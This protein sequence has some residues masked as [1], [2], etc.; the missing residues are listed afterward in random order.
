MAVL[1]AL[2]W[3]WG[4]VAV[5]SGRPAGF[6]AQHLSGAG[7]TEFLGLYGLEKARAG[8]PEVTTHPDGERWRAA[9]ASAGDEAEKA[10]PAGTGVERKGL[11]VTLH[12]RAVPALGPEVD[13]LAA[14]VAGRHGLSP[15][16]GKMS[17]ELRP[18]VEV[19]KGTVIEELSSGLAAVAFAGD[20]IGDLPAFEALDA[21]R[22]AGV[23]TLSVASGG[24]ETPPEIVAAADLAVDG[25]EGI[26]AVL[27]RLAEG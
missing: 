20:D 13:R 21:M 11:T 2:S 6:L 10:M 25:P 16:T 3:R 26:L 24:A 19:D 8:S 5:V 23:V 14:E 22:S 9:V 17:V 7:R 27:R 12:Y 1:S 4:A 18:P 15:H